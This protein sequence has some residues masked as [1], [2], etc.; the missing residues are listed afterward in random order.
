MPVMMPSELVMEV[1]IVNGF[2]YDEV[3][4]DKVSVVLTSIEGEYEE[5]VA[6]KLAVAGGAW[7]CP[8]GYSDT[9]SRVVSCALANWTRMPRARQREGNENRAVCMVLM[10]TSINTFL[11]P[12]WNENLDGIDGDDFPGSLIMIEYRV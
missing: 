2:S 6:G 1:Y 5:S 4:G 12:S 3:D 8:S 11:W 10:D 9:A 7:G